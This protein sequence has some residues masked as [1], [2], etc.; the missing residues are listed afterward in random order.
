MNSDNDFIVDVKTVLMNPIIVTLSLA[1]KVRGEN[2]VNGQSSTYPLVGAD[3]TFKNK[4]NSILLH[5]TTDSNGAF[6]I[7]T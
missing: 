3:F 6:S 4:N 7:I 1:G 2:V 5:G